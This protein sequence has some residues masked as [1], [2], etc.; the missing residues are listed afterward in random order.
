[1]GENR[2]G[3][4]PW[5]IEDADYILDATGETVAEAH[6]PA[7]WL[8]KDRARRIVACVNA[9]AGIPTEALEA[10]ALGRALDIAEVAA[11]EFRLEVL[12]AA[13][14]ALWGLP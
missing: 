11:D 8:A 6:A 1:M 4:E 2:W 10:G 5:F 3:P 12:T 14:R 9:C 7:G 13:F